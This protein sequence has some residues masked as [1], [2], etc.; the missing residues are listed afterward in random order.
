MNRISLE[1]FR[2]RAQRTLE[3]LF[4]CTLTFAGGD[5][6]AAARGAWTSTTTM[7]GERGVGMELRTA[8]VRVRRALLEAQG[9]TL[10]PG[11]T[12]LTVDGLECSVREL[13]AGASEDALSFVAGSAA[14][15]APQS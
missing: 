10:Q 13:R 6:I 15:D 7:R 5:D 14:P 12:T 4:P 8:T 11:T 1:R 3:G 9:V 2:A